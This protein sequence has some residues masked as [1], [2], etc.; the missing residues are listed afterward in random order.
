[1]TLRILVDPFTVRGVGLRDTYPSRWSETRPPWAYT[2]EEQFRVGWPPGVTVV[3]LHPDGA[4]LYERLANTLNA[5]P[6]RVVV[7]LEAAT[8]DLTSFRMEGA[9]GDPVYAFGFWFGDRLQGLVGRGADKTFVQMVANSMTTAQLNRMK[10][11]TAAAFAPLQM[12][13]CRLDGAPGS[14]VIL[15]G[16]TFQAD[17]QQMLTAVAPDVDAVVPQPAPHQGVVIYSGSDSV[18]T[19]CRFRGA[20]RALTPAPPFEMANL[21]SQYGSHLWK[22]TEFDGRRSPDRMPGRPR[23]VGL[24]ML[25]NETRHEMVDCWM[26]HSNTSRYAANDENRDTSGTYI[27]RGCQIDHVSDNENTDPALNGGRTLRGYTNPSP[28]G[29]ESCNG[30]IVV[31]KTVVAQTNPFPR[32]GAGQIPTHFQLTSV[33]GRDPRGGRFE[34]IDNVY[35]WPA[36]PH[37]NGY[38]GFSVAPSTWWW[39]DGVTNTIT[40]RQNDVTLQPFEVVGPWPPSLAQL[41]AAGVSYTTHYLLRR[42][43]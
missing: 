16:I 24:V 4:T 9:S 39:R 30:P 11:M 12:A 2:S 34:A 20:G 27:A 14:P 25:N 10:T 31:E 1:M 7:Q 42:F 40:V 5:H 13:F 36:H 26:H 28:L 29:W 33:G 38:A 23:R 35:L 32:A 17:D 37:L 6:G 21:N 22:N 41:D 15:S 18:V 3:P 43:S 8:Y 19:Y